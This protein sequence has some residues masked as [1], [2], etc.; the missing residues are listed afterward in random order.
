[1]AVVNLYTDPIANAGKGIY[2][3]AFVN[4]G[5]LIAVDA[6]YTVPAADSANSVYR[7]FK[8]IDANLIPLKLELATSSNVSTGTVHCGVY[9]PQGGAAIDEDC[10]VASASTA[11]A[12]RALDMMASIAIGDFQ[13]TLAD[14]AVVDSAKYPAVDIGIKALTAFGAQ[15]IALR[16]I[17]LQKY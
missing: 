9:Y 12:G 16:G 15:N 10:L 13:K 17:F 5:R 11:T 14:L 1:M 2:N 3:A 6:I 8:D 4:G 7:M